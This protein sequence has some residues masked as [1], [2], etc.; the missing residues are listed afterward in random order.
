[1]ARTR[2]ERLEGAALDYWVAR[3]QG[4]DAV[5]MKEVDHGQIP[6][7][8]RQWCA[9]DVTPVGHTVFAPSSN[10]GDGGP[11]ME[12][13]HIAVYW[14]YNGWV[15]GY[16]LEAEN[17]EYYSEETGFGDASLV[18]HGASGYSTTS[19]LTAAMRA[20]VA[21]R[22]GDWVDDERDA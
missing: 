15:A 1:M 8:G 14:S 12:S 7:K 22:Y 3:A 5:I 2:V 19:L 17:G 21:R 9:I 11:I 18:F 13:E 16:E 6:Y 20:K 10:W 4:H